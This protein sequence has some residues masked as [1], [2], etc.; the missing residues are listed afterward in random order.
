MSDV[1]QTFY[2]VFDDVSEFDKAKNISGM[3]KFYRAGDNVASLHFLIKEK[4]V[5]NN[6]RL[7][8]TIS[9]GIIDS[10]RRKFNR[11]DYPEQAYY[12]QSLKNKRYYWVNDYKVTKKILNELVNMFL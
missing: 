11:M 6:N 5:A 4:I 8:L 1:A 3:G 12:M 7:E 2:K 10:N 9:D